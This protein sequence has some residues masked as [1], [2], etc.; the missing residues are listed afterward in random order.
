MGNHGLVGLIHGIPE[1]LG[2]SM[3]G[4]AVDFNEVFSLK[5]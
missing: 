5:P 1:E 2:S 4:E 3:S